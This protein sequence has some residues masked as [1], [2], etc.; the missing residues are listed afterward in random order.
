[1]V[2]LAAFHAI[3]A[4]K[5]NQTDVKAAMNDSMSVTCLEEAQMQL[6]SCVSKPPTFAPTSPSASPATA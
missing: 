4:D 3:E 1:M 2:T 5:T 6:M